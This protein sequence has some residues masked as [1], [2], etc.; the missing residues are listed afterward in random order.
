MPVQFFAAGS[1]VGSISV[2][3]LSMIKFQSNGV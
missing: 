3:T 2:E 1:G